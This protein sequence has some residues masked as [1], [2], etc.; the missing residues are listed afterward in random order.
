MS[1]NRLYMYIIIILPRSYSIYMQ[2]KFCTHI[3]N[4][5]HKLWF[6]PKKYQ[7]NVNKLYSSLSSVS[8]HIITKILTE[9][10]CNEDGLSVFSFHR[11]LT[12]K[13]CQLYHI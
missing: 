8:L 5:F 3:V 10:V 2:C 12:F 11:A 13:K 1:V 6:S 9:N 4:M 7:W